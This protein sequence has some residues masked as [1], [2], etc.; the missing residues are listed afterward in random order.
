MQK[1]LG[2]SSA[3]FSRSVAKAL[4]IG[5]SSSKSTSVDPKKFKKPHRTF[6]SKVAKKSAEGPSITIENI[7]VIL[8][9]ADVL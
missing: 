3:L 8:I 4:H 6:C 5:S 2:K 9:K 7:N 1:F